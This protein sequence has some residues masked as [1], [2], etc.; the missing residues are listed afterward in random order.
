MLDRKAREK[1][2]A[3]SKIWDT[4]LSVWAV[5][6]SNPT[7]P[8]V[9]DRFQYAPLTRAGSN[10]SHPVYWAKNSRLVLNKVKPNVYREM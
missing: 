9:D 4:H 10:P 3:S 6:S 5:M 2:K 8:P 1:L 7:L